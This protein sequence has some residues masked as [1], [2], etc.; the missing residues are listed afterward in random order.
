MFVGY[1]KRKALSRNCDLKKNRSVNNLFS[2]IINKKI[3]KN[4]EKQASWDL[5]FNN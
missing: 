3:V 5:T 2:I 4:N 1:Y